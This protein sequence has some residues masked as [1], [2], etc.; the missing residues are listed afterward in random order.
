MIS[1]TNLCIQQHH[2]QLQLSSNTISTPPLT[3]TTTTSNTTTSNNN[4]YDIFGNYDLNRKSQQLGFD[5]NNTCNQPSNDS[6]L[7]QASN[8]DSIAN[9]SNNNSL[10][11]SNTNSNDG[12]LTNMDS[13]DFEAIKQQNEYSSIHIKNLASIYSQE[14]FSNDN[15]KNSLLDSSN[16]S[17]TQQL[18]LLANESKEITNTNSL[19]DNDIL[20]SSNYNSIISNN[21]NHVKRN[22]N[23]KRDRF[24]RL[25]S[26]ISEFEAKEAI[27]KG[28]VTEIDHVDLTN[29]SGTSTISQ[30]KRRF[31]E[32]KPPYS[33]IALITMA[34]ESSPS[35]MMTLNEIYHFIEE[36]FPYFKDNTQ[37]WQNSIRHN[38][39]LNDCFIKVSKNAVKPGKGNYWALHPKAGD[40]FGN[41]SFLR[42][43]KR[44]K[45]AYQKEKQNYSDQMND[46]TNNS[47]SLSTSPTSSS[48]GSSNIL[49]PTASSSCSNNTGL[50]LSTQS[51]RTNLSQSLVMPIINQHPHDISNS[52]FFHN[53]N[54]NQKPSSFQNST[55]QM[56]TFS[57]DN[58]KQFFPPLFTNFP[59]S[60]DA[61]NYSHQIHNAQT[62][63]NTYSNL[64]YSNSNTT[65]GNP[66]SNNLAYNAFASTYNPAN[67]HP[68]HHHHHHHLQT[69][70]H[71][72]NHSQYNFN[73]PVSQSYSLI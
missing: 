26:Q 14:V 69:N 16:N 48:S 17:N 10:S 40:M 44:F 15:N 42:R 58:T 66:N 64:F 36:R 39:S 12:L 27:E 56:S 3:T 5:N 67:I 71:Q 20:K 70:Q 29:F 49:S 31:A 21:N 2:Q 45:S 73:I 18:D 50:N 33:Y 1:T 52:S 65:S 23:G 8:L 24:N 51:Q 13:N 53:Y 63:S 47:P 9:S 62:N 59:S 30:Q 22:R 38:L 54:N 72:F 37:R 41:G 34:I 6:N 60:T 55:N 61:S 28:L 46:S 43:S 11:H 7:I 68:H 57:V 19:I 35:G 4:L 32:V 25:K